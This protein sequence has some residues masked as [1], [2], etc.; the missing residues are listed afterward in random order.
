[1]KNLQIMLQGLGLNPDRQDGYYSEKTTLAVKAF[2]RMNNL[3]V[4]GEVDTDT[5]TKL[6]KSILTAIRDPK[7]D[8]QLKAAVQQIQSQLAK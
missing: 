6:E 5:A 4:T 8:L 3:P 1:M 2:Q 7:N